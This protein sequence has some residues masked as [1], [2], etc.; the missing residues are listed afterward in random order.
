MAKHK[1]YLKKYEDDFEDIAT[2]LGDLRYDSLSIFLELL[3]KKLD[4][5]SIADGERNRKK[6]SFE[7][8]EAS[9]KI[10]EASKNIYICL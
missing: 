10:K 2:E 8:L 5:D 9:K 6:L 7:L 3:S 4:K 1:K